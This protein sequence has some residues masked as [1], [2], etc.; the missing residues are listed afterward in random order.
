MLQ[1]LQSVGWVAGWEFGG[2]EQEGA[3]GGFLYFSVEEKQGRSQQAT[4]AINWI[5]AHNH[6][7]ELYE[8][9]ISVTGVRE[10]II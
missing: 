3:N 4:A 5:D 2:T 6:Q 8:F 10:M 7:P 9:V 1:V